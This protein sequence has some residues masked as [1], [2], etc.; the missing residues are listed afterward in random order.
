M[1]AN[2]QLRL[3]IAIRD[4]QRSLIQRGESASTAQTIFTLQTLRVELENALR[5][6]ER[7]RLE[8]QLVQRVA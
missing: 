5:A 3:Q 7:Q 6:I 8:D 4:A 1:N 2:Q